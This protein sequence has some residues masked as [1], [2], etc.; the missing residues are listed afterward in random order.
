[1]AD[2]ARIFEVDVAQIQLRHRAARHAGKDVHH[3]ARRKPLR[4]IRDHRRNRRQNDNVVEAASQSL[5]LG[6]G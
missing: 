4:S 6:R 3:P 5:S 1:M 2:D